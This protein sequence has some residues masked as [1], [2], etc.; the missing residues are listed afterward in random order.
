[1]KAV[2]GSK[3]VDCVRFADAVAP[4]AT[5]AE[6]MRRTSTASFP[7]R[8]RP[9]SGV[10]GFNTSCPHRTRPRAEAALRPR[11]SALDPGASGPRMVRREP[12]VAAAIET[13]AQHPAAMAIDLDPE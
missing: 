7:P 2:P 10:L 12:R 1:M 6:P 3:M 5:S 11:R 8:P 9:E 4:G 13:A